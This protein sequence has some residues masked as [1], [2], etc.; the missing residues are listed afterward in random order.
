M[1]KYLVRVIGLSI[2]FTFVSVFSQDTQYEIRSQNYPN[3]DSKIENVFAPRGTVKWEETFD[4]TVQ[5]ADWQII[6]NDGSTAAWDFRQFVAFT[7]GDSV[8]PQAGQSFWFSNFN[9]ANGVG[10]IDEWLISPKLPEISSGDSL[11]FYAGAIGGQFNDSLKVLV[12][13]TDSLPGSFTEIAYFKVDGP[14]SSW[15]K[16]SFDLTPYAGNQIFFAVNYYIVDGGPFGTHS[17]NVWVDHFFLEGP[18]AARLQVIHNAADP[19]VATVDVYVNGSMFIDNFGFREATSFQDV[20]AGVRLNIGVAPGNSSSAADTLVNIPVVLSE[21]GTYAAIANGVLD[22]ASFAPNPDGI[23]T[24]FQLLFQPMAQETANSAFVEFYGV[25]GSTDAPTADI[26]ARG[27]GTLLDNVSYTAVSGYEGVL[28][29]EYILDVK[30]SS[31]TTTVASFKAD[32]SGLGGGAAAV[33][34]SGFLNPAANQNGPA[35]GLIAIL[36]DGTVLELPSVP[37]FPFARLQVVHNAADPAAATVDV[38]VN[39]AMFIDNFDFREATP[40]QD[41]PAGV[42]LDIGVAPGNSGSAADTLVNIPV[43]LSEGGTFAAIANGVLNPATF[44]PNPDGLNTGFQLLVQ[45]MARETGSGNNVE[46]YAV[47]GATDAP[48]VDIIARGFGALYENVPYTGVSD[49]Q[50]VP[51][52]NYIIDIADSTGTTIVASFEANLLTLGGAS[53]AIIAS[54]FLNPVA[55]Q[56][57]PAFGLIAVLADGTVLELPQ[58]PTSITEIENA[59]ISDF[60]LEQNYP[61]PFNPTT[62]ISF[63]IPSAETVILKIYNIAGQEVA[64]LVNERKDAG[65]YQIN[66]DASQL[67]SGI[68]FYRIKAGSFEAAKRM[69]L[70]K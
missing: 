45:P 63:S 7:S 18:P 24:G 49:Y 12:S 43:V 56:N 23:G 26:V 67:S 59:V 27:G 30:D 58:I 53:V 31:G 11:H 16:Y 37:T 50:V 1:K 14:I 54:G 47:H 2:I 39:G 20:P 34:A 15:N 5:P 57:G 6:D 69:A 38:Y 28:P 19:A 60:A 68:Y 25:H 52:F 66:F 22:P 70:L 46:F 44:T 40:F 35:F 29:S 21:G 41:V 8:L 17:D 10:L 51:P 65:R 33:I 64:T 32:L 61:N 62:T 36:P 13:A 42:T 3:P 55:N 48:Y 9:N 4:A